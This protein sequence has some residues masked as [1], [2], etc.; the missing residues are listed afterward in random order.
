MVITSERVKTPI[1]ELGR[2]WALY[3]LHI[4]RV[5]FTTRGPSGHR[6]HLTVYIGPGPGK[7]GQGGTET[8]QMFSPPGLSE[9]KIKSGIMMGVG[10]VRHELRNLLWGSLREEFP[11]DALDTITSQLE[12]M[13]AEH[14]RSVSPPKTNCGRAAILGQLLMDNLRLHGEIHVSMTQDE[15]MFR[16][17]KE[18]TSRKGAGTGK[19]SRGKKSS[20]KEKRS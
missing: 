10:M 15:I 13:T 9:M 19:R 1:G 2:A 4:V 17:A 20:Q 5:R 7:P 6:N 3:N 18:K 8:Y 11:P 12:Q 16:A 14:R